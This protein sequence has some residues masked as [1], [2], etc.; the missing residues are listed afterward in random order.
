MAASLAADAIPD[1]ILVQRVAGGDHR[2]FELLFQRYRARM[3]GIARRHGQGPGDADDIAQD[4]FLRVWLYARQWRADGARFSTW[5]YRVVVNLCIDR[6]RRPAP[7]PLDGV[8][9]MAD[10]APVAPGLIQRRQRAR[11]VADAVAALPA[12]QRQAVHL[13]YFEERSNAEAAA[14]MA[15]SV[16]ALQSLLVRGRRALKRQLDMDALAELADAG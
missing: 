9:D 11:M 14:R 15:V 7:L 1:A 6:G 3:V 2:A 4:A 5:L 8:A 13:C 12:T 16:G 10:T